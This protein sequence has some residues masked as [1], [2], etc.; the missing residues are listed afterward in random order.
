MLIIK[1][2]NIESFDVD[3]TLIVHQEPH[4]IPPGESVNVYDA[5]TK[6]FITVRINRNMIRLLKEAKSRGFYVKVW[7]KG[8]WRW[9]VD[10]VKALDLVD[11]VD[12]V[13]S[14]PLHY[15]DDIDVSE[16]I[17]QRVFIG[18]DTIYKK[19]NINKRK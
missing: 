5:V 15:F 6:K 4:T 9:A 16:W 2:E 12:Q 14:K 18:L 1:N 13:E 11:F 10:V 19:I 8:G 3:G 17:G 7:S